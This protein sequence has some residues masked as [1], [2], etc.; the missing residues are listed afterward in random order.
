MIIA[1]RTKHYAKVIDGLVQNYKACYPVTNRDEMVVGSAWVTDSPGNTQKLVV[2]DTVQEGALELW[3][4]H[5][6]HVLFAEPTPPVDP[7]VLEDILIVHDGSKER[8]WSTSS[9]HGE[10]VDDMVGIL[11]EAFLG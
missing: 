8:C 3:H 9:L 6:V 5:G 2:L 11:E 10:T 7:K 4:K 1:L